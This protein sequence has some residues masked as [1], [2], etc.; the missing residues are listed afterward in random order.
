MGK[1]G[2]YEPFMS[3]VDPEPFEI[4][5]FGVCTGWGATGEWLIE[6]NF[7]F[8]LSHVRTFF[9]SSHYIVF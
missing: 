9:F 4:G 7:L 2:E 8:T 5:Y 3:F 6:G 1:E